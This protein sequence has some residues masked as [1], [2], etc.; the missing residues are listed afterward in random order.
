MPLR[1]LYGHEGLR[2]RLVGAIASSRLPQAILFEGPHGVGKQRLA[3]WL[4]QAIF[5]ETGEPCGSCQPCK[6]VMNL[7]HPDL[8]WIVPIEIA[9]KGADAGKQVELAEEA[10]A[11][12][13]AARRDQPLYQSPS[14]LASHGIASARLLS[15]HLRLTPAVARHKVFV[16]GDAER[17]VAQQASPEAA[18]ALLKALEEPPTDTVLVLTSSE[19]DALPPTVLSRVARVRVPRLPDSVVTLFAQRELDITAEGTLEQRVTSAEGSIGR[20]LADDAGRG[21]NAAVDAALRAARG[22]SIERYAFA[23]AQP[24]FQARGAFTTL[25]NDLLERLRTEARAGRATRAVVAA[26]ARVFDARELAQGNVN[27]QLLAAVLVEDLS[28]SL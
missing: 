26:M 21:A 14:G 10:L 9:R 8:H 20:L 4:A 15:R 19:P 7:A 25:L 28:A 3:L 16:V 17:L 22:S 27:P 5:C 11:E 6:L 2:R 1:P 18:N 23:L 12:E 24:P 13:M